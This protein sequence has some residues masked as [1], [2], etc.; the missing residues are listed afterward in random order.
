MRSLTLLLGT[1]LIIFGVYALVDQN[2]QYSNTNTVANIGGLK[3]Q[4]EQ[5]DHLSDIPQE[6]GYA[7][8][9]V[10]GLLALVSVFSGQRPRVS[11]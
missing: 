11:H 9:A 4:Q 1:L 5:T 3:I 6:A 10:G 2:I 7:G 8:L